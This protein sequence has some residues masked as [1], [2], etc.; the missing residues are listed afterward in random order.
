VWSEKEKIGVLHLASCRRGVA[1]LLLRTAVG[2]NMH[3][4]ARRRWMRE[5]DKGLGLA[6]DGETKVE[7]GVNWG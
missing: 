7:F 5:K 4:M 1:K 3:V 6:S 2:I